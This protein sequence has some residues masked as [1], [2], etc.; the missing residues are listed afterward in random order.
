VLALVVIPY[1]DINLQR[2][3]FW[4]PSASLPVRRRKLMGLLAA[5][6]LLSFVFLFTGS[7]PVW[8][9]LIPLWL[10]A[11][12]MVLPVVV[13]SRRGGMGALAS[14]SL[15]FWIFV[16]FLLASIAL[17]VIGTAFRG[18]GWAYTLPWRDGI[19]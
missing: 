10:V 3:A 1:F 17:T 4:D 14:A 11:A 16:W 19:Y 13:P 8:P 15:S 12:A 9:I 7:H 5:V 6:V 18:P 2:R